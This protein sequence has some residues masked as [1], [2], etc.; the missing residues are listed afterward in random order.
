MVFYAHL[1][2][3]GKY[4]EGGAHSKLVEGITITIENGYLGFTNKDNGRFYFKKD[5]LKQFN[6][7]INEM[8]K[9][10]EIEKIVNLSI[11]QD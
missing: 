9:H 10:G 1:K 2:Q 8:K 5:F 7:A 11:Q 6:H 4:D 3:E